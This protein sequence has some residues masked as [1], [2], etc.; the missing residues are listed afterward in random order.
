M[1]LNFNFQ[2]FFNELISLSLRVKN[3][4]VAV[5]AQTKYFKDNYLYENLRSKSI[6]NANINF[7]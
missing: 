5:C 4:Y 6:T 1:I 7:I 3:A 2:A